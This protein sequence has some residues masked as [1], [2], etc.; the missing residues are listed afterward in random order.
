M[1]KY[2]DLPL[3]H[4]SRDVLARMGRPRHDL[5]QVV[6][7]IR[8]AIPDVAIRSAFIVG[9]PGETDAEFAELLAFLEDAQLDR[10]GVFKYS[11]EAG[12]RA[13]EMDGQVSE[14]VKERRFRK[15]MAAQQ[16]ISLARNRQL[17]GLTLPVLVEG[18]V[19][20]KRR[21]SAARSG[22]LAAPTATRR[23]STG[24]FIREGSARG[25][26]CP[27]ASGRGDGL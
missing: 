4:A 16:R 1:V 9:F 20:A 10:V 22:R 5:R 27:G 25:H 24:S 8:S 2:V 6:A 12:T 11:R 7:E 18:R 21:E 3:Q 19:E 17:V 13:G 23:R 15:A 26:D 14:R